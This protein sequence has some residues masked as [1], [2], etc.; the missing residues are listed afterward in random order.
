M[1]MAENPLYQGCTYAD[2]VVRAIFRWPDRIALIE[3]EE[4]VTYRE[5]GE[6]I[7]RFVQ[8]FVAAA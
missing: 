2:L 1:D 5:L 4:E 8:A 7:S 6:R 3:R